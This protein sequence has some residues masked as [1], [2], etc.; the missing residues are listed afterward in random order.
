MGNLSLEMGWMSRVNFQDL[1]PL[2]QL[3]LLLSFSVFLENCEC[4]SDTSPFDTLQIDRS[5]SVETASLTKGQPSNNPIR[6]FHHLQRRQLS[7]SGNHT[8]TKV[9]YETTTV[10][11]LEMG[12]VN[13]T[14]AKMLLSMPRDH[15]PTDLQYSDGYWVRV[16]Q[17]QALAIAVVSFT[18][19]LYF[20]L[21]I[22][23]VLIIKC[24]R[25]PF[26][27][28]SSNYCAVKSETIQNIIPSFHV[29]LL[30]AI[31]SVNRLHR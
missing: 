30:C 22:V 9:D 24:L 7:L 26:R 17:A 20:I 12:F 3:V 13:H 16:A 6:H 5:T 29:K 1:F 10:P 31:S 11:Q 21:H 8:Q 15:D 25:R 14:E 2:A 4:L 18:Y 28:I 19:I 23:Y 27:Y